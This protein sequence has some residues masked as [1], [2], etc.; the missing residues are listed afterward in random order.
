MFDK[1]KY[2]MKW[3]KE[4]REEQLLKKKIYHQTHKKEE[5]EYAKQHNI[6]HPEIRH[7][8]R[9]KHKDRIS[10]YN[11]EY[12]KKHPK[13]ILKK[14]IKYQMFNTEKI[15]KI[16]KQSRHKYIDSDRKF[17][18]KHYIENPLIYNCR[19]NTIKF[20]KHILELF[21][22]CQNCGC[23]EREI[24][25]LRYDFNINNVSQ[26]NIFYLKNKIIV[27]C[28]NCHMKMHR[29]YNYEKIA[30]ELSITGE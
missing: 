13:T 21:T 28:H 16:K 20:R 12:V 30:D 18:H 25:H 3:N 10:D 11:K 8:Q 2:M 19:I 22:Y 24:H 1:K 29:K 23:I 27:L 26:I 6:L 9:I 4:H 17:K 5:N 7:N 15:S 14:Y